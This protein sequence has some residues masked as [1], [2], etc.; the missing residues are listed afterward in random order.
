MKR[1][2]AFT[3]V[4][5]GVVGIV[6]GT[7]LQVSLAQM[8]QPGLNPP[9]TLALVLAVIG[10][11]DVAMAWPIHKAT[12]ENAK[13]PVDPFY[14]TRVVVLAKSSAI[15]G[16]LLAGIGAG[17]ISYF[18]T[19]AVPPVGSIGFSVAMFAGAVVLMVCGLIAEQM[20]KLPPEDGEKDSEKKPAQA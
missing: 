1:T 14:A 15:S 16:A 5:F 20:C 3:L 19:R 2:A 12:R 6:M 9:L 8:G 17:S 11:L 4:G 13:K 10:A 7:L 18:L